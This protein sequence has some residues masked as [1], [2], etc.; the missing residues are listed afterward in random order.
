M[1]LADLGLDAEPAT[2]CILIQ[3]FPASWGEQ[4][5]KLVFALYGGVSTVRFMA[6]P[7]DSSKRVALIELKDAEKVAKAA[8]QLS[9]GQVGDGELIEECVVTC[10][11]FGASSASSATGRDFW[12]VFVDELL[13]PSASQ[14]PPGKADCEVFVR[15]LP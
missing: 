2:P 12:H 14:S 9:N 7:R 11:A 3:G 4:Q 15:S 13:Q 6:D 1:T 8:E 5:V 10:K